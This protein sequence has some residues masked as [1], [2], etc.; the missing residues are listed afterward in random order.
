MRRASSIN[1]LNNGD[2]AIHSPLSIL[3]SQSFTLNTSTTSSSEYRDEDDT[4]TSQ[5]MMNGSLQQISQQFLDPKTEQILKDINSK[6]DDFCLHAKAI[7]ENESELRFIFGPSTLTHLIEGNLQV[8]YEGYLFSHALVLIAKSNNTYEVFAL[9]ESLSSSCLVNSLSGSLTQQLTLETNTPNTISQPLALQIPSSPPLYKIVKFHDDITVRAIPNSGE[10]QNAF[11]LQDFKGDNAQVFM[12]N[13]SHLRQLWIDQIKNIIEPPFFSESDKKKILDDIQ[14]H[15]NDTTDSVEEYYDEPLSGLTPHVPIKN[16]CEFIEFSNGL[17][18]EVN[19]ATLQ[20]LFQHLTDPEEHD[21]NF[22]FTFLLT[23]KSFTTSEDLLD[24]LMTR[25]NTAPP[26]NLNIRYNF[27]STWKPQLYDVRLKICNIVFFWI[28][29]HF[30]NFRSE[31]VL[32]HKMD[33]FILLIENTKMEKAAQIIRSSW[34]NKRKERNTFTIQQFERQ[35]RQVELLKR[36]YAEETSPKQKKTNKISSIFNFTSKSESEAFSSISKQLLEDNPL[37]EKASEIAK[38]LTMIEMEIFN[39]IQP[40]ECLNQSWSKENQRKMAPNIYAQIQKTNHMV[41]FVSLHI[42]NPENAKERANVIQKFINIAQ[43]LRNLNNFNTLKGIMMALNSNSVF[44]LKKSWEL[45]T[46]KKRQQ[47]EELSKL[48][49]HE[50]NFKAL[51][52]CMKHTHLPSLPYIG[53][54]LSDLTFCEEGNCDMKDGTKINFFKRRQ[55]ASVIKK[56]QKYQKTPYNLPTRG[57]L[58]TK[59]NAIHFSAAFN[60]DYLYELS[61]KREPRQ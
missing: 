34:N 7:H 31:P 52:E 10:F 32:Q 56:I 46:E 39:R 37:I 51:R 50:S 16:T 1:M 45:V 2:A 54:F 59:L 9:S 38:H 19:F 43:E 13:E 25:Y 22:V 53:V 4:T 15:L 12:T 55:L 17:T 30:Y 24:Y 11:C 57:E 61:L 36:Q 21:N 42:L 44:R 23:Y 48:V 40:K 27:H 58:S 28:D 35:Q 60:E 3:S 8:E 20:K 6:F 5:V 47:F 29:K 49:S 18:Q 14:K 41:T 33:K 26:P